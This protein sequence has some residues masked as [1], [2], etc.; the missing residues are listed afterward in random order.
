MEK[1]G[2][3]SNKKVHSKLLN[4]IFDIYCDLPLRSCYWRAERIVFSTAAE[5]CRWK[6]PPTCPLFVSK[7]GENVLLWL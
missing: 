5:K 4:V 1:Y 7:N 6:F 3:D 2:H